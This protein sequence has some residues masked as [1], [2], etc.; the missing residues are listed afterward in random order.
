M[1]EISSNHT[2]IPGKEVGL[3]LLIHP[4]GNFSPWLHMRGDG[5]NRV[6]FTSGESPE[7]LSVS[8][9]PTIGYE[10]KGTETKFLGLYVPAALSGNK[11]GVSLLR[12]LVLV[13]HD[14]NMPT[15]HS[16]FVHKPLVALMLQ[17]E[18]WVPNQTAALAEILP[19]KIKNSD[20]S[21]RTPE[22]RWLLNTAIR[23]H[24]I[25]KTNPD[26]PFYDLKGEKRS[27]AR[28]EPLDPRHPTV[29]LHTPYANPAP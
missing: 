15:T 17:K 28:R 18:G 6:H 4:L 11:L 2:L 10:P 27:L 21:R 7:N 12:W 26:Y 19:A 23:R 5:R 29:Y 24:I 9:N 20:S 14:T 3:P 25:T 13:T 8:N 1:S 22:I 16:G